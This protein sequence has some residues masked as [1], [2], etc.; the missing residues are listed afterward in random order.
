MLAD[1][2]RRGLVSVIDLHIAVRS[3]GRANVVSSAI[4]VQACTA[5]LRRA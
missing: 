5:R 1:S 2:P 3:E 4:A